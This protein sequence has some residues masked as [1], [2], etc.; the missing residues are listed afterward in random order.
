MSWSLDPFT[1][2]MEQIR[3]YG[4]LIEKRS[5]QKTGQSIKGG[6]GMSEITEESASTS[7]DNTFLLLVKIGLLMLFLFGLLMKIFI[8]IENFRHLANLLMSVAVLG[9]AFMYVRTLRPSLF[10]PQNK[11]AGLRLIDKRDSVV[12]AYDKKTL[13]PFERVI[14]DE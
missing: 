5:D 6:L 14:S 4:G 9:R 12:P 13:T 1:L 11:F 2:L 8:P 10:L 7:N 3:T